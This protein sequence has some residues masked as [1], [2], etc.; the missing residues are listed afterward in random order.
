MAFLATTFPPALHRNQPSLVARQRRMLKENFT[1]F[2]RKVDVP[3]WDDETRVTWTYGRKSSM[4][5]TIRP[6]GIK[7][8][9][10]CEGIIHPV[11]SKRMLLI[12][13]LVVSFGSS[14]AMTRSLIK[15]RRGTRITV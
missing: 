11:D 10:S 6:D 15:T 13:T 4:K 2:S 1:E 14:S 8:R 7:C 3:C 12:A 5:F 9:I